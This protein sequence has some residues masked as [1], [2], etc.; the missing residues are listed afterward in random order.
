MKCEICG[1][2]YRQIESSLICANGHTIQNTVEVIDDECGIYNG[3]KRKVRTVKDKGVKHAT[4]D[5]SVAS[6]IIFRSL[7]A[8]AMGFFGIASD[9]IYRYYTGFFTLVADDGRGEDEQACNPFARG[10]VREQTVNS[11]MFDVPTDAFGERIEGDEIVCAQSLVALIYLS[12]RS[13]SE[14][15][16]KPYFFEQFRAELGRFR[17]NF[18]VRGIVKR[19]GLHNRGWV[20][21]LLPAD[22]IQIFYLANKIRQIADFDAF[23]C[24]RVEQAESHST[25][26]LPYDQEGIK[27]NIRRLFSRDVKV[28]RTYFD[29]FCTVLCVEQTEELVFYFEKYVCVHDF[30][31]LLVPELGFAVFIAS[32]FV[33]KEAFEST[34]VEKAVL[35]FLRCTRSRLATLVNENA[36][37]LAQLTSPETFARARERANADRF[38]NLKKAM[39]IIDTV[40][41]NTGKTGKR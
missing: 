2:E 28:L 20:E 27:H 18:R 5:P 22:K 40:K 14:S 39:W 25:G 31:R 12:K 26:V 30:R 8:E 32:Y 41:E 19:H 7:F 35:C 24:K 10:A 15:T 21:L 17:L 16:G 33:D 23:S 3:R 37:R 6:F 1:G 29:H 11:R 38:V 36:C 13:E 4:M 34:P 9:R